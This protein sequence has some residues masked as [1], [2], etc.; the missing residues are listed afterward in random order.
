MFAGSSPR[1][2][3]HAYLKSTLPITGGLVPESFWELTLTGPVSATVL[4]ASGC[5]IKLMADNDARGFGLVRSRGLEPPP[6]SGLRPQRSASAN[7]AMTA[8]SGQLALGQ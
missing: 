8:V 5:H 7:S 2:C 1:S 4:A 3:R 6:L